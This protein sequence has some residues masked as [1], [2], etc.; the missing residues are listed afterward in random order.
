[1]TSLYW[2]A[3]ADQL[4]REFSCD[5]LSSIAD[6]IDRELCRSD[7]GPAQY[8]ALVAQ[9]RCTLYVFRTICRWAEHV[10]DWSETELPEGNA[11]FWADFEETVKPAMARV[12]RSV[13]GQGHEMIRAVDELLNRY[14]ESRRERGTP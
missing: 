3:A 8:T 5:L 12:L 2:Q 6:Q 9:Q 10:F 11:D 4:E 7:L 13:T 14:C 1:M